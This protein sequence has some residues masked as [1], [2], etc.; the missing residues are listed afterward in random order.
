MLKRRIQNTPSGWDA[1]H[2]AQVDATYRRVAAGDGWLSVT[3][4]HQELRS[5]V[6]P[7]RGTVIV[8]SSSEEK[9]DGAACGVEFPVST[10]EDIVVRNRAVKLRDAARLTIL[11]PVQ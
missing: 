8:T 11:T 9:S 10:H 7:R 2:S 4:K 6:R 1:R 3:M 5:V